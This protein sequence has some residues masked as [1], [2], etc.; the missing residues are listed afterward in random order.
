MKRNQQLKQTN[1]LPRNKSL[2]PGGFT[3][4]FY[5]TCREELTPILLKL[6][7]KLTEEGMLLNSLY[8]VSITLISKPD[9]DITKKE[10]TDQYH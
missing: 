8:E 10:I 3:G 5:Q 9:K 4:E 7:Q 1:K 6:F 2:E